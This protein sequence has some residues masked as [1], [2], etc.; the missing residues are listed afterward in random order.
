MITNLIIKILI[1]AFMYTLIYIFALS[2]VQCISIQS[3]GSR[4]TAVMI[5]PTGI[6]NASKNAQLNVDSFIKV[7][8]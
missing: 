5:V 7:L 3:Q 8:A 1:A 6:G 4:Y 2:A